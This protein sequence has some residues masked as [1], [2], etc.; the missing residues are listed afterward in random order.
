MIPHNFFDAWYEGLQ[1]AA[2]HRYMNIPINAGHA[3]EL[4]LVYNNVGVH[5]N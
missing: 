3:E 5:G 1:V 2:M 4:M